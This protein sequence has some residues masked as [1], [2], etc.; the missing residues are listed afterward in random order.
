MKCIGQEKNR[1]VTYDR[2]DYLV[3]RERDDGEGVMFLHNI[4]LILSE[5][6]SHLL[7]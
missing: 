5:K 7:E 4:P 3:G 6:S 1:R 2:N